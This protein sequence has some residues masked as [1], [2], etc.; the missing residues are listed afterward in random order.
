[1][2]R[3]AEVDGHP[4]GRVAARL[5]RTIAAIA[6]VAVLATPAAAD[7]LVDNL[8]QPIGFD[9]GLNAYDVAQPF[10]T[11]PNVS[12]YL[13]ESV[14]LD[15]YLGGRHTH[16]PVYVYL[17]EDNG[18]GRPNHSNGGQV[19]TLTKNGRTFEGPVLGITKYSVWRAQCYPQPPHGGGCEH[20]SPAYRCRSVTLVGAGG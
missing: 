4:A 6:G 9:V 18:N 13:L 1:M 16:D 14:S 20:H 8:T 7:V 12:G 5:V 17:Q 2:D 19:A 10:T 11:G 15:F 3:E